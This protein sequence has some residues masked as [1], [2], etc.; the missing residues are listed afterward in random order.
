MKAIDNRNRSDHEKRFPAVLSLSL[1]IDLF[2]SM[3]E[4]NIIEAGFLERP[5]YDCDLQTFLSPKILLDDEAECSKY[6]PHMF[7]LW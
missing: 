1:E 7:V 4:G 2:I 6:F 5:R 3:S